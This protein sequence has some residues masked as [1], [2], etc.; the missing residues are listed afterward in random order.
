[1]VLPNNTTKTVN[2]RQ[3]YPVKRQRRN[4]IRPNSAEYHVLA[5]I[6]IR[7]A[8]ERTLICEIKDNNGDDGGEDLG[9]SE[10]DIVVGRG[11]G[12]KDCEMQVETETECVEE[13]ENNAI[14]EEDDKQVEQ[15]IVQEHSDL[16]VTKKLQ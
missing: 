9:E 12:Q 5:D 3:K 15:E 14:E 4:A 13:G 16:A 7:S 10:K 11:Q 1:M 2:E 6:A 8:L